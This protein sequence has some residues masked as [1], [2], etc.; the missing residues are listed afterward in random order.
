MERDGNDV[1]GD[2]PR[3]VSACAQ[4]EPKCKSGRGTDRGKMVVDWIQPAH[5]SAPWRALM[6]PV[7]AFH[8]I[9]W[10]WRVRKS[11]EQANKSVYLSTLY[12]PQVRSIRLDMIQKRGAMIRWRRTESGGIAPRIL[13]LILALHGGECSVSRP[14]R[15]IPGERDAGKHW[16]GGWVDP[17]A[18]LDAAVAKSKSPCQCWESNPGCPGR[19]LVNISKLRPQRN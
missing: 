15:F 1:S 12:H 13:N 8:T 4:H 3:Q 11:H 19:S 16:I 18:G 6:M 10:Q 14:S 17:G 2:L 9:E 7:I 5:E